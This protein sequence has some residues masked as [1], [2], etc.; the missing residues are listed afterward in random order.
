MTVAA[1]RQSDGS[2]SPDRPDVQRGRIEVG[3]VVSGGER[4]APRRS[5]R[6]RAPAWRCVAQRR[7]ARGRLAAELCGQLQG[8]VHVNQHITFEYT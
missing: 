4:L 1:N 7:P 5:S 8:A 2:I 3:A 6:A